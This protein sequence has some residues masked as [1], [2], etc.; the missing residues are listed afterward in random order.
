MSINNKLPLIS[1]RMKG[2]AF[3]LQARRDPP[4]RHSRASGNLLPGGGSWAMAGFIEPFAFTR[5]WYESSIE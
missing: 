1:V 5:T 2:T 3:W 4:I